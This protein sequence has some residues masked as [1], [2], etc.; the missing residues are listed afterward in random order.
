MSTPSDEAAPRRMTRAHWR[1]VFTVIATTQIVLGLVTAGLV[2]LGWR[3]LDHNIKAGAEI[4]HYVNA[5]S[6]KPGQANTPLNILVLGSDTRSGKGNKIDNQAGGGVSDTTILIHVAASRKYAYGISIPRDALVNPLPCSQKAGRY[7]NKYV[8][9][10]M[11]NQFT[12]QLLW[13][14]AYAAG[15]PECTVEQTEKTFGVHVD[16][17]IVVD[18]AGFKGMV[19]AIG[20]VNVCI[21]QPINDPT[22]THAHL[23]AGPSVHLTGTT[24]LQYV[25]VRHGIGDG[26]DI[27]RMKRQQNFV[28][29][30]IN[31]VVSA[32][33]L[34]R[35]D[36]LYRFANALTKSIVTNPEIASTSA[37]INLA[38]QVRGANLAH[39]KF[40]SMPNFLFPQGQTGYPHVGLDPSYKQLMKRVK[41]DQTLGPFA[42]TSLVGPKKKLSQ[43]QKS[44]AAAAGICS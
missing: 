1:T 41:D 14:E 5:P 11:T 7:V 15:G 2:Y 8:N 39:I 12:N 32:H 26:T 23:P 16:D 3:H 37:L 19:D 17:Y 33:T 31:Q 18:F 42:K 38:E 28:D 22:Y 10:V 20:G 36:L 34:T 43:Q 13:N 6:K 27:G 35:P 21:P 9:G 29:A 30:V 24:A 44:A 40:I 25:R 4:H